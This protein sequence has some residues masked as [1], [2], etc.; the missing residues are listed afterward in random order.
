MQRWNNLLDNFRLNKYFHARGGWYRW[1]GTFDPDAMLFNSY[2]FLFAFLPVAWLGYFA[3]GRL[4]PGLAMAW[5]VMA[6]VLFYGA[7]NPAFVPL[8]AGSVLLNFSVSRTILAAAPRWRG[9]WLGL[10]L[11][12]NLACLLHFKYLGATLA[13]LARWQILNVAFDDPILPLGISFFTFTQIG[14][15]LDCRAGSAGPVDLLRY[16]LFVTV[17]PHLIAGPILS[18]REMMPQFADPATFRPNPANLTVGIAFLAIGLLKKCL[19]ADPI[20]TVVAPGFAAAGGLGLLAAWQVA[21][22]YSLQLYFDFS[23]YSDMAVGLAWMFNL[24][25]PTNFNSPYKARSVIDYWQRWHMSLTRYLNVYLYNPIA[26]AVLRRRVAR[27]K[28]TDRAAQARPGGFAVMIAL[29]LFI[30]M[31]LAGIWHGAGTQFVVFGL[32]HALYL[33]INHA[34]RIRRSKATLPPIASIALTYLS[35][36]VGAVFFRAASVGNALDLLGGM[37]GLHGLD[38]HLPGNRLGAAKSVGEIATFGGLYA[39]VW[40]LPN[41]Q[42]IIARLMRPSEKKLPWALGLGAVL[43]I[44][45]LSIGGTSEFLYFQF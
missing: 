8:L 17:F 45:L 1:S 25:F 26:L 41:S 13:L 19:L 39:I 30:T 38:I 32:L 44:A 24:K 4:S 40:L 10:G 3:A 23:G 9:R 36:L 20:G 7:W 2:P 21:C 6:S 34:W 28:T 5:L 35:V 15:L 16:S 11:G 12:L 18:H 14:Y 27:G 42:A 33:S 37:A 22:A 43:A 31:T 29:P